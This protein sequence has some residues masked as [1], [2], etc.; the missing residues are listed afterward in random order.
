MWARVYVL[1][2]RTRRD[3]LGEQRAKNPW[4]YP[5]IS[6]RNRTKPPYAVGSG[7][8]TQGYRKTH[9]FRKSGS[10]SPTLLL[11]HSCSHKWEGRATVCS[12]RMPLRV[13]SSHLRHT[14][15]P[16]TH[17]ANLS[18]RSHREPPE[19]LEPLPITRIT[20]S[21]LNHPESPKHTGTPTEP[22]DSSPGLLYTSSG[23]D[24]TVDELPN[25]ARLPILSVTNCLFRVPRGQ[26]S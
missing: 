25:R 15:S 14:E 2:T 12:C 26:I 9:P 11:T 1:R 18:H 19:S 17:R 24:P 5:G 3:A 20:L 21:H 16:E 6:R 13:T 10:I 4:G 23:S 22:C 8:E 7:L